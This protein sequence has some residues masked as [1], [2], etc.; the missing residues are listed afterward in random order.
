[1]RLQGDDP[2]PTETLPLFVHRMSRLDP[3]EWRA[4]EADWEAAS[5]EPARI[6][7]RSAAEARA[8]DLA[9][10]MHRTVEV[11]SDVRVEFANKRSRVFGALDSGLRKRVDALQVELQGRAP[12]R[13]DALLALSLRASLSAEDFAAL[14][15]PFERSIPRAELERAGDWATSG[16][17]SRPAALADPGAPGAE[18]RSSLDSPDPTEATTPADP[19]RDVR[20][21]AEDHD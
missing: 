20:W 10:S 19:W 13:R 9:R 8:G 17:A 18:V 2:E 5:R 6:A 15:A 7:A 21:S 14:Y 1:M 11:H 4:I 12:I 16:A 3:D